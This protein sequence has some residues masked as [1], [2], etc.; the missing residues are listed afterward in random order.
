MAEPELLEAR[1]N[2]EPRRVKWNAIRAV[3]AILTS[4]LLLI[5]VFK[6]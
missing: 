2:F 6:V 5:L 4:G 3:F 1:A